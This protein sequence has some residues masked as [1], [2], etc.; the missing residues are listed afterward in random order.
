MIPT[1]PPAESWIWAQ[2]KAEAYWDA[3]ES[4]LA[5]FLY[6]TVLSHS[7]LAR[8]LAFYLANQLCSPTLLERDE[9]VGQAPWKLRRLQARNRPYCE[10]GWERR[11]TRAGMAVV[12]QPVLESLVREQRTRFYLMRRWV[13]MIIIC[14]TTTFLNAI[15]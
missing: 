12:L 9:A 3:E 11:A 8:S 6:A 4:A 5:S 10:S 1:F 14:V 13:A 15:A 2:I 7:S